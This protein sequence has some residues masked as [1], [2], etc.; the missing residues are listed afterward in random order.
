MK[1]LILL[2]LLF[3]LT[4][5]SEIIKVMVMDSGVDSSIPEIN[6]FLMSPVIRE[7]ELVVSHGT[8]VTGTILYGP[9]KSEGDFSDMVCNE[10]RITSC[11]IFKDRGQ[12][13]YET[14]GRIAECLA[15]AIKNN[16][17]YINMS[18]GGSIPNEDEYRLMTTASNKGI[19]M[20]AAA[21]NDDVNI[22][23]HRY[24]PA[25][26]VY[27]HYSYTKDINIKKIQNLITIMSVDSYGNKSKTSS[28]GYGLTSELGVDVLSFMIGGK[29]EKRGGTSMAAAVHTHK[30]IKRHCELL[31]EKPIKT[32]PRAI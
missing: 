29:F 9:M 30:L 24:Y 11:Q 13:E 18:F 31:R 12:A 15:Y 22:T 23:K 32:L 6:R 5:K 7:G 21:G 25:A 28:Y 16:F 17:D 4:V 8:H 19:K 3:P 10:V 14:Y 26:Y 20:V 1:L 2:L 27:T